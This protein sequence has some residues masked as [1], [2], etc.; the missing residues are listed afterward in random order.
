VATRLLVHSTCGVRVSVYSGDATK[1]I[2]M[3]VGGRS[4]FGIWKSAECCGMMRVLGCGSGKM[5]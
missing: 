4:W 2:G 3:A 5:G 1:V